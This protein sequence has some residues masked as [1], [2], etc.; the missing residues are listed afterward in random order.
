MLLAAQAVPRKSERTR[1]SFSVVDS[2]NV[3]C[4]MLVSTTIG[5]TPAATGVQLASVTP[6]C[7]SPSPLSLIGLCGC[8][9]TTRRRGMR[10]GA[11]CILGSAHRDDGKFG[12]GAGASELRCI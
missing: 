4:A 7:D 11:W 2:L 6:S 10:R 1:S 9:I 12:A 5:V 3:F 8:C